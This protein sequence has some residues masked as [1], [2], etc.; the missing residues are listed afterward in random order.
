MN[1]LA[2]HCNFVSTLEASGH[3]VAVLAPESEFMS[4]AAELERLRRE[5][6]FIPDCIIQQERLGKRLF[7]R[8][9]AAAPCP[10]FFLAVDSH[11]NMFWH[12]FY[13]RLFDCLLTPHAS[14]FRALPL[15]W[16][17]PEIV[18]FPH[19]GQDMPHVPFA[20]RRTDLGLCARLTKHRKIRTWMTELLAPQGLRLEESLP[21]ADML[22]L[23]SDTRIVPNESIAFEVN[24]RLFEAASCGCLV[25]CQDCGPDQES[26]FTPGTEMLIWRDCFEL[27]E[28]VVFFTKRPEIAEKIGRAARARIQAEH[29]PKHRAATLLHLTANVSQ[30]RATGREAA[31]LEWLAEMELARH[32]LLKIS[33]PWLLDRRKAFEDD[34]EVLAG[35]LRLAAESGRKQ[36]ALELTRSLLLPA[37]HATQSH[38]L[39]LELAGAASA[40]ALQLGDIPLARAHLLAYTRT[41]PPQHAVSGA[42][43]VDI[44]LA[45]A[46][47]FR[48]AGRLAQ[49]GSRFDPQRG[50]LPECA[51]EF[52]LL[53]RHL[54]NDPRE[55]SRILEATATLSA[56]V[57]PFVEYAVGH[58]AELSLHQPENWRVRL[59]FA[60]ACFKACRLELG[61]AETATAWQCA[62]DAGQ[63]K[64]F[65]RVLAARPSHAYIMRLLDISGADNA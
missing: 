21:F 35:T 47:Y 34:P 13:S 2:V 8:D 40:A 48:K 54:H 29:L 5:Q 64:S 24:F 44:A 3:R 58:L 51:Y 27:R 6:D 56:Q 28:H 43:A 23:Y 53:A 16:R 15:E 37:G 11:L 36:D 4:L 39:T 45:W 10:T 20:E 25:L 7:I 52:L 42:C 60:F 32:G 18:L 63:R 26:A 12:R 1:I 9:L 19:I 31:R 33:I 22:A 57:P 49:P 41:L 55:L 17:H 61:L 46:E 14:L 59:D 30:G 50:A 62:L 38:A 65:L